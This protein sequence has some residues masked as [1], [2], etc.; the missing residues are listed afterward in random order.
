[1]S[2]VL[3][4]KQKPILKE[5]GRVGEAIV[6]SG[7]DDE[8]L[9]DIGKKGE[10]QSER[11]EEQL[12]PIT[13]HRH[14]R[15]FTQVAS[16]PVVVSTDVGT[17]AKNGR[18]ATMDQGAWWSSF[19][20]FSDEIFLGNDV[21]SIA[22]EAT[23]RIQKAYLGVI[24]ELAS[25]SHDLDDSPDARLDGYTVEQLGKGGEV[26]PL[27]ERCGCATLV[28]TMPASDSSEMRWVRNR[29]KIC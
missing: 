16:P 13:G 9:C 27:S 5:G 19:E 20:A 23:P 21:R 8:Y 28:V 1:M 12:K 29:H 7:S 10:S 15:C 22:A 6:A 2:K 4:G 26:D 14:Q 24:Y 18:V 3:I 17:N 11:R 25:P